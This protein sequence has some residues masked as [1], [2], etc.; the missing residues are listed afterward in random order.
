MKTIGALLL[1]SILITQ[2]L[3]AQQSDY[4]VKQDFESEYRAIKNRIDSSM[5]LVELDSLKSRLEKLSAEY[6]V[7]VRFLDKALYPQTYDEAID[8]LRTDYVLTYDRVYLI[9]NQGVKIEELEG[10]ILLLTARLDTLGTERTRLFTELQESKRSVA[11]LREAMK[12]LS[13]NLQAKDRLLFA[14]ID[15]IFLP[16]DKNLNQVADV[17]KEA[18]GRKLARAN[19]VVR[20]YDVAADNVRFLESTQLQ[21]KDY[22]SII[23]QYQ[24]FK[25][26]WS[27]L[28]ERFNAVAVAD[29]A[30]SGAPKKTGKGAA[31]AKGGTPGVAQEDPGNHVD[32][33]LVEWNTKLLSV[34]WTALGQE[35]TSKGVSIK[36]FSDG[37]SFSASVRAYVDSA[38]ASGA[39]ASVFVN[40]IWKE[41][42]DKEWRDALSK[43]S[44]LGKVEY[45]ALDKYVSELGQQKFDAKFILYIILFAA[46]VA[47]VW[48]FV[49]RK[50]KEKKPISK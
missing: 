40:D 7:H 26:K 37:P 32:S 50:P 47:G 14:L 29:A 18:I 13:S 35:F 20:V 16:Y 15:S 2:G 12:R 23:E 41:R 6:A 22:A 17:Q 27:G 28:K 5:T 9:Q 21:A 1:L 11:S 4:R 43:Q 39:D 38:K 44:M 24:Q 10:R 48:W 25:S 8:N 36:P 31:A 45:A 3:D 42:I 33:V 49:G 19:V 34:F 46:V 30:Q